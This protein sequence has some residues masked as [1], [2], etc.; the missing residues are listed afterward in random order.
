MAK[1]F[2]GARGYYAEHDISDYGLTIEPSP[3]LEIVESRPWSQNYVRRDGGLNNDSASLNAILDYDPTTGQPGLDMFSNLAAK[4][5]VSVSLDGYPGAENDLAY[6][7]NVVE[8]N[9]SGPATQGDLAQVSLALQCD[10]PLVLGRLLAVGSKSSGGS[11]S[12]VQLG[13]VASGQGIYASLH[14]ITATS[15][16]ITVIIESDDNGGFSSATTRLTFTAVTT[17]PGS[18]WV[19]DIPASGITDDFWRATWS[20]SPDHE[21][22]VFFGIA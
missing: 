13:A 16:S 9:Y 4:F 22:A 6:L 2:K 5:P 15:G 11:S 7:M 17:T 3:N 14:V 8:Q 12:G 10:G 20:G 21:I 1:V 18:E 19:F